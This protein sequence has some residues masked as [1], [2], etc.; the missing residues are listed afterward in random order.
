[1]MAKVSEATLLQFTWGGGGGGGGGFLKLISSGGGGGRNMG[2]H[3][4]IN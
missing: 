1:M 2:S 4:F 3:Y